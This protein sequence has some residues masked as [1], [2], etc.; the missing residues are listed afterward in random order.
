MLCS[1]FLFSVKRCCTAALP[2][3]ML[4]VEENDPP[5]CVETHLNIEVVSDSHERHPLKARKDR[6]SPPRGYT[7]TSINMRMDTE[8]KA[9]CYWRRKWPTSREQERG[10]MEGKA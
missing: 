2:S 10:K 7:N 3:R 4:L 1:F 8:Q 9:P 6:G 5:T